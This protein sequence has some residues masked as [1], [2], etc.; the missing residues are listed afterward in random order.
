MY[1]QK[2][3]SQNNDDNKFCSN[4]GAEINHFD[5]VM[6]TPNEKESESKTPVALIATSWILFVLCFVDDFLAL[7]NF[8]LV[9]V[10]DIAAILC[11]I[12]LLINKNKTAKVNGIIILSIWALSFIIVVLGS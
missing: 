9:I 4:C 1:C 10:L 5:R 8:G 6:I 2:C 3:G 7:N 12:L 11:A